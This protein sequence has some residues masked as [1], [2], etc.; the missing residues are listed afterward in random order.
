MGIAF[1]LV[2]VFPTGLQ[3]GEVAKDVLVRMAIIDGIIMPT[4]NAI[5]FALLLKYKLDR[6][7]VNEIQTQLNARRQL[8]LE[9]D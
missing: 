2:I 4:L 5:P 3:P 8:A 1:D 9:P 7:S 6:A